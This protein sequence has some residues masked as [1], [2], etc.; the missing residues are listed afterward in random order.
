MSEETKEHEIDRI[1]EVLGAD[2]SRSWLT[3]DEFKRA[4]QACT[5]ITPPRTSVETE[6]LIALMEKLP[7]ARIVFA[8][9][10]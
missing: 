7:N 8:F 1:A 4:Y 5:E 9:D 6:A 2:H 10:N 3:T